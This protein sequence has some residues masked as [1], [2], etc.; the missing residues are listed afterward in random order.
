VRDLESATV[1]VQPQRDM[2][3]RR[4]LLWAALTVFLLP[5]QETSAQLT[6]VARFTEG[7]EFLDLATIADGGQKHV[8]LG[9]SQKAAVTFDK[10]SWKN[11]FLSAWARAKSAK[12][13]SFEL[14]DYYRLPGTPM[15][16]IGAG[17]GVR[18]TIMMPSADFRFV[19]PPKTYSKFDAEIAKVSAM[20]GAD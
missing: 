10:E 7:D 17:P 5:P 14:I 3:N 13:D 6:I 12:S 15:L 19:I 16:L 9:I 11:F 2:M 1:L 4:L 8:I 18:F 20:L